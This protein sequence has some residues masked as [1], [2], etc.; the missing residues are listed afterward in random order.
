MSTEAIGRAELHASDVWRGRQ[1]EYL[2][3]AWNSL[4]AMQAGSV[5]LHEI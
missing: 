5:N 4:E 3:I 1:L 2:T